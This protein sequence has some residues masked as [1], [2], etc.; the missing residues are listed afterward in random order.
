MCSGWQHEAVCVPINA[1]A[2]A[3]GA[4]KI[5]RASYAAP[6]RK[7]AG[8]APVFGSAIVRVCQTQPRRFS[9]NPCRGTGPRRGDGCWWGGVGGGTS[10]VGQ[11]S[12]WVSQ[13]AQWQARRAQAILEES[14]RRAR[15][16]WWGE[17]RAGGRSKLDEG[18]RLQRRAA[19]HT[20]V[21]WPGAAT[22]HEAVRVGNAGRS[23]EIG[24]AHV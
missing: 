5:N 11:W 3:I 6:G 1:G 19:S 9:M 21:L 15:G 4:H 10:L 17:G 24:R 18:R 22:T 14:G 7:M 16:T 20:F 23:C 12:G 8:K 2:I 13:T